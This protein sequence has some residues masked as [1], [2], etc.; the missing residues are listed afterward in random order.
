[1]STQDVLIGI[2]CIFPKKGDI[3]NL[4]AFSDISF[5]D[6]YFSVVDAAVFSHGRRIELPEKFAPAFFQELVQ[7]SFASERLVLHLYPKMAS[8]DEIVNYVDFLKSEC[9]MIVLMYDFYYVEIYCKN[10]LWLHTFLRTA[11]DIPGAIVK[12]KDEK[13]DPRITMYV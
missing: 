11:K 7:Q 10:R 6:F 3:W 5:G 12:E 4:F 1:M 2:E 8:F 9:E 13:T